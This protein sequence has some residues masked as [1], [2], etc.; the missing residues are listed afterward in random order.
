M[1]ELFWLNIGGENPFV[2]IKALHKMSQKQVKKEMQAV[3][4]LHRENQK[5]ATTAASNGV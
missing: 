1:V 3:G 4:L 2:M 5:L